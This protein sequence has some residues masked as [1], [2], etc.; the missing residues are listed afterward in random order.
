[1]TTN[2]Q[3][4]SWVPTAVGKKWE[5]IRGT[6]TY[7]KSTKRA[8]TLLSDMSSA[9]T[10]TLNALAPPPTPS[11][12]R[13]NSNMSGI[14]PRPSPSIKLT[15]ARSKPSTP[16]KPS[17]AVSVSLLDD[18]D[19]NEGA[20]LGAVLQPSPSASTMSKLSDAASGKMG[21]D[22]FGEDWNW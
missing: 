14:S 20:G 11:L 17:P 7:A 12:T 6:E 8:S 21:S 9:L 18:D 4:P 3:N 5:E 13:G 22:T 2:E 16:S 15:T 19:G 10:T 1:M